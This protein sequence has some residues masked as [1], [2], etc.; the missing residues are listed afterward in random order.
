MDLKQLNYFVTVVDY[1]SF[2]K[3]AEK[4]HISQPSLSNAIKNLERDLGFQI[5]ERSTRNSRLTEAGEV[6]YSRANHL[7]SEM[8]ILKKEMEEVKIVGKGELQIGMIESVKYWIPKVIFR[9]NERFSDMHIQLTEVLGGD[10]VRNSLRKYETH[11]IITNQQIKEADIETVPLYKEKLVLVL[12]KSHSLAGRELI[13]LSELEHEPFIISTEGFQTREDILRAFEMED[14]V[15][16]VK[17][18]IERFETALSLVSENLGIA[19]IPENYL[20]GPYDLSIV[21]KIIGSPALER[22]VYLTYMKNRYVS[23]SIKSFITEVE[24]FFLVQGH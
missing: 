23:P 21:S 22:T 1:M 8:A 3:A 2:S 24:S 9:Y 20:Q 13:T 12:H 15:P 4:L 19:F 6:L 7:L 18:E 17:Y 14:I 11:A 10:D 5:I 16:T